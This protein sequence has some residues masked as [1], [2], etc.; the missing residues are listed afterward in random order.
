MD[1]AHIENH[2]VLASMLRNFGYAEPSETLAKGQLPVRGAS[3]K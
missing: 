1:I 2:F 3:H